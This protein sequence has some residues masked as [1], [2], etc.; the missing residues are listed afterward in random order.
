MYDPNRAVGDSGQ[1]KG[2]GE[3][4]ARQFQ[5]DGAKAALRERF[6]LQELPDHL[7]LKAKEVVERI[8]KSVPKELKT[9]LREVQV[10]G[11]DASEQFVVR[12]EVSNRLEAKSYLLNPKLFIEKPYEDL[13]GPQD[14]ASQGI[15]LG[16]IS[17]PHVPQ[18]KRAEEVSSTAHMVFREDSSAPKGFQIYYQFSKVGVA[19]EL[20]DHLANLMLD[21]LA[22]ATVEPISDEDF[23]VSSLK[24][25]SKRSYGE[26]K[27]QVVSGKSGI[28]KV[29]RFSLFKA[30]IVDKVRQEYKRWGT[31]LAPDE[32]PDLIKIAVD[33]DANLVNIDFKLPRKHSGGVYA[34]RITLRPK[35]NDLSLFDLELLERLEPV[36]LR[37]FD[38]LDVTSTKK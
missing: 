11:V 30:L 25:G 34:S 16:T 5:D 33:K 24:L 22:K 7:R 13:A 18:G 38:S 19:K 35:L 14:K 20:L 6:K 28:G 27:S 32:N 15:K 2:L 12:F 10:L 3:D 4:L 26:Q 8:R 36:P 1:F 21:P 23:Q 17:K 31:E 29:E 37:K 9:L